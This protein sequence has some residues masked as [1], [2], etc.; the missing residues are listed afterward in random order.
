MRLYVAG[1]EKF[2]RI[3]SIIGDCSMPARPADTTFICGLATEEMRVEFE[4]TARIPE[5]A[6]W[7]TMPTIPVT[8]ASRGFVRQLVS[9][10]WE[11]MTVRRDPSGTGHVAGVEYLERDESRR[12]R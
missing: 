2:D 6:E 8:G 10:G 11:V 5:A 4:V 12:D 7:M 9:D 3:K 1:G